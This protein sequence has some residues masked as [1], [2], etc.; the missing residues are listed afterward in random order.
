MY[1]YLEIFTST[2]KK[3]KKNEREPA[4][5]YQNINTDKRDYP[6]DKSRNVGAKPRYIEVSRDKSPV[7]E[8]KGRTIEKPMAR[9]KE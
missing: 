7:A 1:S 5:L 3:E 2:G 9:G 4:N 6:I 8:N